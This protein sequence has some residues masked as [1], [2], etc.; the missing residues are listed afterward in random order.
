MPYICIAKGR[1][2]FEDEINEH[3][4]KDK[5]GIISFG[6]QECQDKLNIIKNDVITTEI[7]FIKKK[8]IFYNPRNDKKYSMT[9]DFLSKEF[10]KNGGK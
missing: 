6:G 1:N 10:F 2:D 5:K 7:D 8:I 3:I 9:L 4:L